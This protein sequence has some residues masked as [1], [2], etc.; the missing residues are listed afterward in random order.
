M[1]Q[2]IHGIFFERDVILVE[3]GIEGDLKV[4]SFGLISKLLGRNSSGRCRFG[5]DGFNFSEGILVRGFYFH[6]KVLKE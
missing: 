5:G 2:V 3:E 4:G 6:D 1:F